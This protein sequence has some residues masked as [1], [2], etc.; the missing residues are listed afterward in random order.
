MSIHRFAA[1]TRFRW[2]GTTYEIKRLLPEGSAVLED[3][4]LGEA[5]TASIATFVQALFDG[6]LDFV[7]PP[8]GM[9]ARAA[10]P[11]SG[12]PPG[13]TLADYPE[14]LGIIAQWRLTVIRPLLRLA[15]DERTLQVVEARVHAVREALEPTYARS[16]HT[17]VSVA[18]IYRWM[19]AYRRS[20][21][22]LRSLIPNTR[23][24]GGKATSRLDPAISAA[25]DAVIHDKYLV[26]EAVTIDD[27]VREVAVRV[28]DLNTTRPPSEP[29]AAPSRTTIVR[30]I[31]SLDLADRF[32]TKH[33]KRAA[34]RQLAQYGET[35]YPDLPLA[36]VEIDHTR[37]DLI[38]IDDQDDLPLGR[39]TVTYCLDLATR[40]PLGYY[41]GFEPPSYL[42]VMECLYH[43]IRPKAN[44]RERYGTQHD[45][46]AYGVPSTLVIDHARE[47][48]GRD[49]QDACALLD[50]TLQQTP[51][52]TPQFKAG[53]ERLFGSL[54]T[55]LF[56]TLPGTTFSNIQ[57][58]GDYDSLEQACVYLSDIDRIMHLFVVDLYAEK[59]HRGLEGIPARRWEAATRTGFAPRLPPGAA[60]LSVLLGRVTTRTLHH[61]GIDLESLRYNS[62]DL[63]LLRTRL[64][65]TPVKVKYHPGDLSRISIYDPFE[66]RYLAIPA[67]AQEYTQGLS[68]WK[69]RIIRQAVLA[70]QATVDIAALGRARREIQAIVEA[71][72]DR[73]RVG[74]RSRIARWDTAGR[75]SRDLGTD[76][77]D[78]ASDAPTDV[79]T[80]EEPRPAA[81]PRALSDDL[82]VAADSLEGQTDDWGLEFSLPTSRR[83]LL[84][85][86]DGG[87]V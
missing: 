76:V 30:R 56:H 8:G 67:L 46:I 20:G 50:I 47:F 21:A 54:N 40:Y 48:V 17:R 75:P 71:G 13:L 15:P 61:Y 73:K 36:R 64:K 85:P 43:A 18:S 68:L 28:E 22:D 12:A 10:P 57:Q 9:P 19:S 11:A 79:L 80:Q 34:R 63:A 24:R 82:L 53:I 83:T 81:G 27:V 7:A 70:E 32:A 78:P 74:T 33:G 77:R 69:H 26:R 31:A 3:I 14:D 25:I 23:A 87:L 86:P 1:G 29:F 60:D 38:V 84:P 42:T 6:S 39:L 52:Q 66:R 59:F 4:C 41:L 16:L 49:L 58:R 2:Q 5:R 44:V 65:G 51:V 35:A 45:W 72:R 55:M 62:D 37:A